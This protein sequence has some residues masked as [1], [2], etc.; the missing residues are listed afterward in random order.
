MVERTKAADVRWKTIE[1]GAATTVWAAT[2][3]EL[4]GEGGRYLE[5]C[6]IA[7]LVDDPTASGGV[8][9]YAL[10]PERADAL[11]E[12]TERAIRATT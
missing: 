9:A 6:A 7:E 1:Q 10:D 12:W 11:W 5:D 4:D 2:A 3:P 8:R